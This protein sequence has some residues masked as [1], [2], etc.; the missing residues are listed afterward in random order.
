MRF[1]SPAAQALERRP[2]LLL[3]AF[4]QIPRRN[5]IRPGHAFQRVELRL[6]GLLN[7]R[8]EPHAALIDDHKQKIAQRT[9]GAHSLHQRLRHGVLIGTRYSRAAEQNPQ[10]R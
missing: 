5:Y 3:F 7:F 2:Q 6:E 4:L 8:K 10:L 9:A 1:H